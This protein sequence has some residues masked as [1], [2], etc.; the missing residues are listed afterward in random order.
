MGYQV[1]ERR[2]F[3]RRAPEQGP[4]P[5][6]VLPAVALPGVALPGAAAPPV[7]VVAVPAEH[8]AAAGVVAAGPAPPAPA[9][10][11]GAV[12]PAP[13]AALSARCLRRE[14]FRRARRVSVPETPLRRARM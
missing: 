2:R 14:P 3:H 10:P 7:A 11:A 5:A 8:A 6:A 4:E 12:L 13:A 1:L 9:P